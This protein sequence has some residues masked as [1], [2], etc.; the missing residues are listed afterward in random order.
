M[1]LQTSVLEGAGRPLTSQC[2][3]TTSRT[4]SGSLAE[5]K[6]HRKKKV[7]RKL[8]RSLL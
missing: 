1:V 6:R 8:Y 7:E 5:I 3:S 2:G 4:G